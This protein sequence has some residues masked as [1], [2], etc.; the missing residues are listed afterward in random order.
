MAL[1]HI[2]ELETVNGD[3]IQGVLNQDKN[4]LTFS[5][6]DYFTKIIDLNSYKTLQDYLV[7]NNLI[8]KDLRPY[9]SIYGNQEKYQDYF[10]LQLEDSKPKTML[11]E[12]NKANKSI[13]FLV[14]FRDE[15][16]N[17]V[18]ANEYNTSVF[19]DKTLQSEIE[20]PVI[21][22]TMGFSYG[23][24]FTQQNVLG[25]VSPIYSY[26][27]GSS[28]ILSFSIKI[29]EDIVNQGYQEGDVWVDLDTF[30][31]S[32]KRLEYPILKPN[33]VSIF[34]TVYFQIGSYFS[35]E[36]LVKTVVRWEKPIRDGK[37][38]VVN[39][40]FTLTI[41]KGNEELLSKSEIY[42]DA[43][44]IVQGLSA[45][46]K[47]IIY[48]DKVIS[49][50]YDIEELSINNPNFFVSL[51]DGRFILERQKADHRF[52]DRTEE[53][54]N[55][56]FK[57]FQTKGVS[58]KEY[59]TTLNELKLNTR[60]LINA[61]RSFSQVGKE[62]FD[63]VDEKKLDNATWRAYNTF[64]KYENR[65]PTY[66]ELYDY[67]KQ[68]KYI[69][70]ISFRDW[71]LKQPVSLKVDEETTYNYTENW[72]FELSKSD[73]M[74]NVDKLLE[75]FKGSSETEKAEIKNNIFHLIAD[76]VETYKMGVGYSASS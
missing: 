69:E 35:G 34:P 31:N 3:F 73:I 60:L 74:K 43:R 6:D 62:I 46:Y 33:G 41:E 65:K 23:A 26:A 71:V 61:S 75:H 70:D 59:E 64:Q 19:N 63:G 8:L 10:S 52:L 15:K 54:L 11:A 24:N 20:I 5:T 4:T 1:L 14:G 18:L 57:A 45:N 30:V 49:E 40:D 51:R 72:L 22:D 25:R 48:A 17:F 44:E 21:P 68:H 32:L 9:A 66:Y 7:V 36:C 42:T 50:R 2:V 12:M 39:L 76:V 27:Y 38:T 53:K 37:Y 16:G 28:E 29:N 13:Y 56:I 67:A 55:N 47:N 58:S